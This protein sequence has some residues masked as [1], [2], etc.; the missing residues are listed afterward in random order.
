MLLHICIYDKNN[1]TSIEE[2][3]NEGTF[4]DGRLLLTYS[5]FSDPSYQCNNYFFNNCIDSNDNNSNW[6]GKELWE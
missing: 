1:E 4:D 5:I 2:L 3:T 6:E